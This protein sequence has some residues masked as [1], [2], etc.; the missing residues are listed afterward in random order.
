V[1][2]LAL[3]ICLLLA[4]C[5]SAPLRVMTLNV[6]HG[7]GTSVFQA[8]L[9]RHEIESNLESIAR[10][11]QRERADVVALQEADGPSSWSGGFDH[12][13]WLAARAGYPHYF[14]G[15]HVETPE[16]SYG[17]ALLAKQPLENAV[18]H[19]F[20]PS[21]PTP[22]KGFVVATVGSVDVV[23]VHLDFLREKARESQILE[24]VEALRGRGRPLLL[25]GDLNLEWGETLRHL[26][27]G[28][29]LKAFSPE[30]TDLATF[31]GRRFDWIL[32]SRDLEVVRYRVV[33]DPLSDHLA[34]VADVRVR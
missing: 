26:A 21:L 30:A 9:R 31:R 23:S 3:A 34:V 19:R 15:R 24:V 22:L 5:R 11:L 12:V 7:R 8:G 28:L 18:S 27:D 6:A 29:D 33:T 4:A 14:R 16:F 17:T 25:L 1:H 32:V 20:A 2:K 13:R 10:V